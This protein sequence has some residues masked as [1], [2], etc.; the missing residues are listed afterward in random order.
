MEPGELD[1]TASTGLV[2][3][4]GHPV[5][6]SLSP[7]MHNAAFRAQGVDM[8]YLAFDVR[9]DRLGEALEGLRA[10]GLRGANITVPHKERVVPFLDAVEPLA[11]RLGAVNTIVHDDGRLIGHNTDVAG[12]REALRTVRPEGAHGLSCLVVGAGG[13]ARA[14][15]A[16][17]IQDGAARVWIHNRT[18]MRSVSLCEAARRW[19]ESQCEAIGGAD[20][21][22]TAREAELLVNATSVGL[23][24]WVKDS[25]IPVDILDSHHLV[26]DVVYGPHPTALVA[27]AAAVGAIALDGRE[28]LVRQAADSYRLWTG[29]EPP[30]QVMRGSLER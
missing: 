19:G 29:L 23:S 5:A 24:P 3:V 25:A 1:V 13:A 11:A 22:A 6:H 20:V 30:L 17:L 10:L 26:M 2:A 16:A 27:S 14:V 15:V 7:R 18:H 8:V 4:L 9:P 21:R 28:M 12:F